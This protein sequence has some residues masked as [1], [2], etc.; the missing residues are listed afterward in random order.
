MVGGD[1]WCVSAIA[2]VGVEGMVEAYRLCLPQVKLYGPTNF[3]PIIRHVSNFARQVQQQN[4]ASVSI[5]TQ[6]NHYIS[7]LKPFHFKSS[8]SPFFE[9]V[10]HIQDLFKCFF[11]CTF[12]I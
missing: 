7:P 11:K 1:V 6:H 3:A 8:L 5:N 10:V 2:T 9:N 12:I 4:A